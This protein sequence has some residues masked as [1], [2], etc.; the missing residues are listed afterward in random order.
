MCKTCVWFVETASSYSPQQ[1]PQVRGHLGKFWNEVTPTITTLPSMAWNSFFR[2]YLCLIILNLVPGNV[3][4]IKN[5]GSRHTPKSRS[6]ALKLKIPT[7]KNFFSRS[8]W[9]KW[10][11]DRF[12]FKLGNIPAAN[13][14]NRFSWNKNLNT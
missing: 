12:F 7:L 4:F 10:K 5:K 8:T 6:S 9:E 1:H 11:N 2:G 13:P 14:D 3:V